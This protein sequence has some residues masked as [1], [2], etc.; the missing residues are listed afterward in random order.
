ML[1]TFLLEE[2]GGRNLWDPEQAS[3]SLLP[4]SSS[5]RLSAAEFQVLPTVHT[6]PSTGSVGKT[7]HLPS[8]REGKASST[9]ELSPVPT[10]GAANTLWLGDPELISVSSFLPAYVHIFSPALFLQRFYTG[11]TLPWSLGLFPKAQPFHTVWYSF[12]YH[13]PQNLSI[14]GEFYI[15]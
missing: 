8:P 5:S 9:L 7:R 10:T 12:D 14:P 13:S 2:W 4:P 3:S 11:L 6:A 1:P 15:P